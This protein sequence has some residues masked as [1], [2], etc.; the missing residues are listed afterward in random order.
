MS[1]AFPAF[2]EARLPGMLGA[3][4]VEAAMQRLGWSDIRRDAGAVT[5]KVGFNLWS[6][7]ETVTVTQA[8]DH[9]MLRSACVMPTQC[10]DWGKNRRNVEA[11]RTALGR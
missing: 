2:H 9:L 5:G 8:R 11:L 10:F 7:G 4:A 6:F 1:F 3:T